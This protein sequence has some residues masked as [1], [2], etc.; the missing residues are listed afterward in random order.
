MVQ[1]GKMLMTL[2]SGIEIEIAALSLL[3]RNQLQLAAFQAIPLP[4]PKPFE[5]VIEGLSYAGSDQPAVIPANENPEYLALVKET[6]EKQAA[7]VTEKAFGV[8]VQCTQKD[9]LIKAYAP[10]LAG[11]R[12][13]MSDLPDDNWQ[14]I[15]KAFLT[16]AQEYARIMQ[17]IS[18][19]LP[20][21]DEEVRDATGYFRI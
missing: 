9:D 14:A 7:W 13:I 10:N 1:T 18:Q 16:T 3:I 2:Q 4:D 12:T 20:L 8:C 17:A 21:T 5:Q 15:L 11:L 19:A 6:R